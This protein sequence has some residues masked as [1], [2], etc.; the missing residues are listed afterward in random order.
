[1]KKNVYL[2]PSIEEEVVLVENGIALSEWTPEQ[3]GGNEEGGTDSG[4]VEGGGWG[5]W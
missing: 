3:G 4:T 5:E 1:M 2:A